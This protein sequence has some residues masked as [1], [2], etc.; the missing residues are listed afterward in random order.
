MIVSAK[1]KQTAVLRLPSE[2]RRGLGPALLRL[3]PSPIVQTQIRLGLG[4]MPAFSEHEISTGEMAD[5]LAYLRASRWA[6]GLVPKTSP[7]AVG[8]YGR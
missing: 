8:P 5:L 3:A 2:W 4:A 7:T 6:S 1:N